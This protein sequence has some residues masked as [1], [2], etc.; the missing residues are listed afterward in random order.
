MHSKQVLRH[1]TIAGIGW[2]SAHNLYFPAVNQ[3]NPSLTAICPSSTSLSNGLLNAWLLFVAVVLPRKCLR[4]SSTSIIHLVPPSGYPVPPGF[5]LPT[6]S[7]CNWVCGVCLSRSSFYARVLRTAMRCPSFASFPLLRTHLS[8][9]LALP[10]MRANANSAGQSGSGN[11]AAEGGYAH[12]GATVAWRRLPHRG[13]VP[14]VAWDT[15]FSCDSRVVHL[16]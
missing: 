10:A 13:V 6:C 14:L 9:A 7:P 15:S 11:D 1:H 3:Q 12:Y 4:R 2:Y 5:I 16:T 8:G